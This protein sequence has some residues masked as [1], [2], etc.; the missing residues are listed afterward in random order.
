[1]ASLTARVLSQLPDAPALLDFV[2]RHRYAPENVALLYSPTFALLPDYVQYVIWIL[3]FETEYEMQG[4]STLLENALGQH[5]PAIALSFEQ[6]HNEEIAR[7]LQQ[8]IA[9]VA[10]DRGQLAA[11]KG[12]APR[13]VPTGFSTNKALLQHLDSLE[14]HLRPLMVAKEYWDNVLAFVQLRL[15]QSG[16]S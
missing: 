6:T 7:C 9:L 8:L 12:Q 11:D 3:D 10:A 14:D 13:F 2:A 1:M 15:P 5:L 16:Q 4:L